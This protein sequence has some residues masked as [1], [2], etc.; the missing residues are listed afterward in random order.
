MMRLTRSSGGGLTTFGFIGD[1][2]GTWHIF[3]SHKGQGGKV[4]KHKTHHRVS[5]AGQSIIL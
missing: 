4:R 3:L 5:K 1:R 2:T